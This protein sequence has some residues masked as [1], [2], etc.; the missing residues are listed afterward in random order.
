MDGRKPQPQGRMVR[1]GRYKYCVYS[2]GG[3][4]ESLVDM[5]N[6]PGETVNLA[7][8]GQYRKVLE[9]HRR[10]LREW[11]RTNGDGFISSVP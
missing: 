6:D 3:R 9:E 7:E 4:R 10:Y 1:S 2:L 5:Q 8:D 11:C